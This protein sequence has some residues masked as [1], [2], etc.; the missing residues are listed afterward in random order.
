V[1]FLTEFSAKFFEKTNKIRK[2]NGGSNNL[3]EF[4]INSLLI[5]KA[6]P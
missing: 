5:L 3:M 4:C 2:L 6:F 1:R